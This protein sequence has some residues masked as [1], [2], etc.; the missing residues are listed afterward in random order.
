M[1][2]LQTIEVFVRVAELGSFRKAA[3]SLHLAPTTVSAAVKALEARLGVRL[4]QRTTRTVAL[5]PDGAA[6]LEEARR[7]L[8]ELDIL[9][10][11]IHDAAS[12]A[13][14]RLRVD[15]PAS[16]ARHVL[17]P[18][19]PDFLR[20]HPE[21]T[22]ELGSSDRPVD[23]LAEGVDCAVRGGDLHDDGLVA[24]RLGDLPVVTVA[25][26]AY[27]AVHGT[28]KTADALAEHAFVGFFSPRTGRVFDVEVGD[29]AFPPRHRVA[30][31]DADTWL[32]LAIA[33]L[34]LAQVP[35]SA[36]LRRLI[37][38]GAIVRV[39]PQVPVPSLPM[40]VVWPQ[41]R[42]LAARVRVFVDWV[43]EVYRA[44]VA[45]AEAYVARW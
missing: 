16:A 33:G 3:T 7:L 41:Q 6:Y 25:A 18:G 17:A 31:N 37:G 34:G 44:E 15:A 39:L 5:T 35:A 23:L 10:A 36:Q 32:A 2:R 12:V 45:I 27:L 19:L 14:G 24:R 13:R 4:L 29:R 11:G 20:R 1:D 42:H 26:P 21:L 38:K 30:A 40:A 22:V 43:V 8:R 9:E 28:P